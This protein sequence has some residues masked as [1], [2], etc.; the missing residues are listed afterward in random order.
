[1]HGCQRTEKTSKFAEAKNL[2]G[3]RNPTFILKLLALI[4]GALESFRRSL[5]TIN[6]DLKTNGYYKVD[7]VTDVGL[8][9]GAKAHSSVQVRQSL[10]HW[11]ALFFRT[12]AD[13]DV[14]QPAQHVHASA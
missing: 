13:P 1:M 14:N 5:P 4:G 11:T 9:G 8:N 6:E 12:A 2:E 3:N 7:Q 10:K